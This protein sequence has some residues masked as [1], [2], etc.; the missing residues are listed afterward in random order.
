MELEEAKE[1]LP[2]IIRDLEASCYNQNFINALKTIKKE[3]QNSIPKKKIED[4]IEEL[5]VIE[6][7]EALEAIMNRQN[8]TITELIQFVLRDLL[9]D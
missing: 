9:E 8:Y 6:N 7:A 1:Y 4:K 2:F 3:L 5:D